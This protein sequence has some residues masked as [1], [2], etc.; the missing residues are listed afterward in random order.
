MIWDG[1]ALSLL[2]QTKLPVCASYIRC[3]DC[4]RVEA[5]IRRLEVRGEIGR[6]HV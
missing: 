3:T 5:A 4:E 1:E 2:D 6:A